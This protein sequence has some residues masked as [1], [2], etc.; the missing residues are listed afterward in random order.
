MRNIVLLFAIWSMY[1]CNKEKKKP[2]PDP[3]IE[4][5][6]QKIMFY[7]SCKNAIVNRYVNTRLDGSI[8]FLS[9][10][11]YVEYDSIRKNVANIVGFFSVN[12]AHLIVDT[13][14]K[15]TESSYYS[16]FLFGDTSN[17]ELRILSDDLSTPVLSLT[18]TPT[19]KAA[20]IRVVHPVD[21]FRI[22]IYLNNELHYFGTIGSINSNFAPID[23]DDYDISIKD[24]LGTVTYFS[25]T[26]I[27]FDSSKIYTLVLDRDVKNT[28]NP[29]TFSIINNN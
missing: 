12:N 13:S 19:Y 15:F 2:N 23:A 21:T 18:G 1:S 4:Y 8:D 16:V 7:N 24:I 5:G 28:L 17:P 3:Q 27:K 26:G 6:H 29:I 20:K 11:S 9:T 10:P 14:V 22:A 25:N